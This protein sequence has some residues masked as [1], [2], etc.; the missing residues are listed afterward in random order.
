MLHVQGARRRRTERGLPDHYL[1]HEVV[2]GAVLHCVGR[3]FF[4][5]RQF[6]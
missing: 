3:F 1:H 2:A 4:G 6:S 5:L